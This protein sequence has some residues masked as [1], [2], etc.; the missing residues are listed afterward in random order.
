MSL[1]RMEHSYTLQV[2]F[3]NSFLCEAFSNFSKS[4]DQWLFFY[5]FKEPEVALAN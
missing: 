3:Q 1:L 5:P 4:M 2:F